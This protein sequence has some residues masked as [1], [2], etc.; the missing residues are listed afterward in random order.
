M[1]KTA[2]TILLLCFIALQYVGAQTYKTITSPNGKVELTIFTSQWGVPGYTIKV[3]G[4]TLI[5]DSQLGLRYSGSE[6]S[7]HFIE[8]VNYKWERT[9][10]LSQVK[11]NEMIVSF[12]QPY[13]GS[14][15]VYARAFDNGYALKQAY[16]LGSAEKT[17]LQDDNTV[18][19]FASEAEVI[20]NGN[21]LNIDSISS[22]PFPVDIKLKDG[23]E[24][25]ISCDTL[26]GYPQMKLNSYPGLHNVLK[27]VLEPMYKGN[28]LVKAVL[29]DAFES[30]FI[31]VE[32]KE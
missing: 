32:V 2:L 5:N 28:D 21:T 14:Y 6:S 30:P 8:K 22:L 19:C 20:Q 23:K 17:F 18:I 16:K 1:K 7:G 3:V 25:T 27:V 15:K 26:E 11:Y 31:R 24:L 12:N 13:K 9:D 29:P 10:S 4:D